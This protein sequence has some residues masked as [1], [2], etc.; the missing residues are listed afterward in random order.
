MYNLRVKLWNLLYGVEKNETE[1][2]NINF[3][4]TGYIAHNFNIGFKNL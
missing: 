3:I 4:V 1:D 2:W